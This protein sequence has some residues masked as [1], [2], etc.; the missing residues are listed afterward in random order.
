MPEDEL[1]DAIEENAR[2]PKRAQGDGG[3]MEQHSIPDLIALDKYKAAK[4]ATATRGAGVLRYIQ[5]VP[6]GAHDVD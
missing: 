6:P 3:S 4:D 2:G 5:L 1:I